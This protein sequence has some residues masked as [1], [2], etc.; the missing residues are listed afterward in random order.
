VQVLGSGNVLY[1]S[2]GGTASLFSFCA[3]LIH[4]SAVSNVG[5]NTRNIEEYSS[6]E[7]FI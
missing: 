6:F 5:A 4:K 2:F 3:K 1:L 7:P